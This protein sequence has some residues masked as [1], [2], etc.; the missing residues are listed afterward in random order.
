[1]GAT[2]SNGKCVCIQRCQDVDQPVCGSDGLSYVNSC[3]LQRQ[4]C[5]LSSDLEVVHSG[6]CIEEEEET[7][8]SG[9]GESQA[10]VLRADFGEDINNPFCTYA[11]L[12]CLT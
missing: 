7:E 10:H 2:C 4:A 11:T 1:M 12:H 8:T 9:T 5:M 6:I 3:E